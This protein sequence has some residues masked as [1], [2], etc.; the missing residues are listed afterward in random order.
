MNHLD[1]P[2]TDE[3]T[4]I[5][6]PFTEESHKK[7]ADTLML[8]NVDKIFLAGNAEINSKADL[9]KFVEKPC[10]AVCEQLYDKNIL[11]CRSS[12]NK[13]SP[14]KAEVR[15]RYESLDEENKKIADDLSARG[16]LSIGSPYNSRNNSEEYGPAV[17][18]CIKTNPDMAVNDISEQLCKIAMN[19][20][21]QDIKYNI[22]TPDYLSQYALNNNKYKTIFG[23]PSLER[24]ICGNDIE[25]ESINREEKRRLYIK[26]RWFIQ[27][28]SSNK[29]S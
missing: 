12:S 7:I 1:A 27:N 17:I 9:N 2:G 29:L 5:G 10:L 22:Y 23:F 3:N 25:S 16:I 26:V 6:L 14:Y 8:S 28:K 15:I 4:I 13:E 11:T 18:L 19:F 21:P 24:T 20:V